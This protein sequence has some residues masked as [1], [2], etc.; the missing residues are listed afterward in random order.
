MSNL[1]T[2]VDPATT[3]AELPNLLKR[4][5]TL[6][7]EISTFNNEI[8]QRRTQSKV[9]K[10]LIL[11]IMD[12]NSLVQLNVSRG[13]IVHK[14]REVSEKLSSDFML[15]HF[16]DFFGG[17]EERAKNLIAYLEERRSTITKHD[18]RLQGGRGEDDRAS[19]RS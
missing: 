18:L 10:E 5:M 6:Q 17:D 11:R 12:S 14:T 9:L 2:A 13:A 16:K 3:I 15:K 7:E 19:S 4:W 8:K 1:V